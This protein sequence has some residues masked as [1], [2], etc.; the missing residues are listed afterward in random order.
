MSITDAAYQNSI[1]SIKRVLVKLKLLQ[2]STFYKKAISRTYRINETDDFL[3]IYK[4]ILENNDFSF[5]LHDQSIIQIEKKDGYFRY[6]YYNV[7]F[8]FPTYDEYLESQGYKFSDVGYDIRE[9]YNQKLRESEL[10]R[11]PVYIRYDYSEEVYKEMC[12]SISHLHIG[13]DNSIRISSSK[14]LTPL[15]F[16]MIV[17][18]NAYYDVWLEIVDT[19]ELFVFF[20]NIKD[21]CLNVPMEYF[22]NAD[23]KELY[24]I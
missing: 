17:L 5:L 23:K 10:K 8:I 24:L 3:A 4:S 2:N 22:S 12:H 6:S 11:Y 9:E 18:K 20:E 1:E 19:P 16:L 7:P 15:A 13:P 14:M 21:G